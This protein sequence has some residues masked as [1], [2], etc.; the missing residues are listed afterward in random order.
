[1]PKFRKIDGTLDKAELVCTKT[2]GTKHD[3]NCFTLPLKFIEKFHNYE[4]TLNEAINNQVELQILINKLNNNYNSWSS[5]KLEVKNKVLE[6]AK[7]L[8]DVRK[9]IIVL[10]KKGIFPFKGNIFKIK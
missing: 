1:M 6:P 10:F 2:D 7:K 5:K 3:F 9:D 8:F 4:I